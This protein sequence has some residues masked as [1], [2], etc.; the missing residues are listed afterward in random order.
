MTLLRDKNLHTKNFLD[1]IF[2]SFFLSKNVF[3][4][5]DYFESIGADYS[6][7]SDKLD[8]E[9][10]IN[11]KAMFWILKLKLEPDSSKTRIVRLKFNF[12][13]SKYGASN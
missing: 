8:R 7:I 4:V 5:E 9:A 1:E 10:I 6:R 13:L 3:I 12:N 2:K 11:F